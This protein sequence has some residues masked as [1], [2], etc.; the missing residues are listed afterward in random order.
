MGKGL[1]VS[2]A[3]ENLLASCSQLV[4]GSHPNNQHLLDRSEALSSMQARAKR[5][6]DLIL[7]SNW[8]MLGHSFDLSGQIDWHADPRTGYGWN[9]TFHGDL[10]L[11]GIEGETDV[12]YPW[13][14][15][16]HQ[17]T[18]ELARN[19][20]LNGCTQSAQ[21]ARQLM[22]D[23]IQHNP[24]YE[25]VNWTSGLEAAMRSISWIWSLAHLSSWDGWS[26]RDLELVGRSL[27]EHG[28]YL[29]NNFSFYS[30]PYNHLIGEGTG[31]LYVA[32]ICDAGDWMEK[33]RHVL[34][35]EGPGQFYDDRFCVEQAVGYHYYTL[36][37]LSL[38]WCA[39]KELGSPLDKLSSII[40]EGYRAGLQF[41]RPDGTWP[42]IGDL[43]S[44]RSIPV[45]PT[46]YW[47]FDSMHNLAAAMF[48]DPDSKIGTVESTEELYWMLG[49]AG[50]ESWQ[51]LGSTYSPNRECLL[52]D[53]GYAIASD[54]HDW[55][56][57]DAG[58]ISAG[59]FSDATP[60]TAHG[61]ADTLQVLYQTGGADLLDDAG[62]PYYGGEQ[63]WINFFRDV[64]AHNTVQIKGA[65]MVR[66]AGR[67]AWSNEV[68]RPKLEVDFQQDL[69]LAW[70]QLKWPGVTHERS[71]CCLPGQGIWIADWIESDRPRTADW[72]WQLPV[73]CEIEHDKVRM[74]DGQYSLNRRSSN[75]ES[76][77]D[78]SSAT[79]GNP[80]GWRCHAY[81]DSL[82]A[83]RLRV[84]ETVN[85]KLLVLTSLGS[86]DR[87]KLGYQLGDTQLFEDARQAD[88]LGHKV[89]Q[90]NGYW[91][92]P[93]QVSASES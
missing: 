13:E 36:G 19:F 3:G 42:A 14:L 28:L 22:L 50:M 52:S 84:S 72:F 81:G 60:S 48:N 47:S 46:N 66:Q 41:R 2:F 76:T 69:W 80:A 91:I 39:A 68:A 57:M 63:N 74:F 9:R 4:P 45:H 11:Y 33:A 35:S 1:R 30:S 10:P 83:T 79:A 20:Q 53:S 7:R 82:E 90:R 43:D 92:F 49:S 77:M 38:S 26:E 89:K 87:S 21:R 25:G 75:I 23:W 29:S 51:T 56:L 73:H 5:N 40:H 34:L 18:C 6:S 61:H 64:G 78:L 12:K 59:L 8:T 17:F 55:M 54:G 62:M 71:V 85:G 70:G 15:S 24:L 65:E 32:A 86:T 37:F 44:A 88:N 93:A 58:P 31:L 27:W 16:R 67:L